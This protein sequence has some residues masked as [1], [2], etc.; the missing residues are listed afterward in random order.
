MEYLQHPF[1]C[2]SCASASVS[3]K[4]EIKKG[5]W[6]FLHC[7]RTKIYLLSLHLQFVCLFVYAWIFVSVVFSSK[8]CQDGGVCPFFLFLCLSCCRRRCWAILSNFCYVCLLYMIPGNYL[9]AL[10]MAVS[11]CIVHDFVLWIRRNQTMKF[12]LLNSKLL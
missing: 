10:K 5:S 2:H 8:M 12:V 6:T 1:A 9:V 4:V 11:E 7:N 3:S